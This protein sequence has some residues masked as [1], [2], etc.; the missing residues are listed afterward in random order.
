MVFI[1]SA[2]ASG[3]PGVVGQRQNFTVWADEQRIVERIQLPLR[4]LL[5]FERAFN[6]RFPTLPIFGCV[7]TSRKPQFRGKGNMRRDCS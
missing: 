1:A 3:G 5:D 2:F 6:L 4:R 7:G